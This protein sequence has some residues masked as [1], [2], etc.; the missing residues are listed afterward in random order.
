MI[1]MDT[2]NTDVNIDPRGKMNVYI[3]KRIMSEKKSTLPSLSN[4]N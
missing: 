2:T 3:I 4:Q 1:M